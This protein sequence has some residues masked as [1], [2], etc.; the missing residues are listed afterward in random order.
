[1]SNSSSNENTE[2]AF[3]YLPVTRRRLLGMAAG[4]G[5]DLMI[6]TP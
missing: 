5:A 1:M 2:R 3:P 6:Q 4:G